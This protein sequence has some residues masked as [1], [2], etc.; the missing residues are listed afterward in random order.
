MIY[1]LWDLH[2]GA[3]L[4]DDLTNLGDLKAAI[5]LAKEGGRRGLMALRLASC[6]DHPDGHRSTEWDTLWTW[7]S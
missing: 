6:Q 4:E 7:E 2:S 1:A 5:Q 3:V